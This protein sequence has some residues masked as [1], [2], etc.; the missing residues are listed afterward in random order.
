MTLPMSRMQCA[1]RDQQDA[2]AEFRSEFSLPE[3]LI[4]LDGNS[5]GALPKA[6]P[7]RLQTVIQQQ[8][9][10]QL[11]RSW[12]DAGWVDMPQRVGEIIGQIIGA[13]PASTLAADSTSI[14]LY[15][16]LAAALALRPERAVVLTEADNFPTDLYI[17]QGL[18]QQAPT[19]R[20]V[21]AVTAEQIYG[22]LHDDVAVLMLSHVNYRNGYRH[23][24]AALTK[25]AHAV[26]ALVI[27]DLA[28]SAG[29][30]PINLAA[31][32]A[33]FAVGCG[34]KYLNGGPGALAF[35][36]VAP[37]H[38]SLC[39]PVLSGWFGHAQPFAFGAEY[40]PAA[41]IARFL[42]G[43]PPVLSMAALE[44][45][46]EL[47]QRADLTAVRAKSE[48]LTE[49]FTALVQAQ[50][51]PHDLPLISPK[52]ASERGSQVCFSHPQAWPIMQA[53]IARGVIGDVRAP[54]I[55]R[56]GFAP[57]Y[58]RFTDVFDAAA[59]LCSVIQSREWDQ[60]IFHAPA[61]VT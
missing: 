42:V 41:G 34:Y 23:D 6:T 31:A 16:V 53:L 4:Y 54:D 55:L 3:G 32:Q 59:H 47:V 49:C 27:W 37:R 61:R 22:Q 21:R 57:L 9:G 18:T 1:Q 43:T 58:L 8:W 7:D 2:L 12:N 15:K 44:V 24:L 50:L 39:R 35:L 51:G 28:H 46:A 48:A 56:F 36:Y 20:E 5:L 17:A 14:N 60:P 19:Q 30:M 52:L 25:A 10:S 26:G 29:V 38:Q 40:E 45:G 13:E 33:D 11:I